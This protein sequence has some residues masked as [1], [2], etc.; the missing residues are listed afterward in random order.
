M[1]V[2]DFFDQVPSDRLSVDAVLA[3]PLL[4]EFIMEGDF[5]LNIARVSALLTAWKLAVE[6]GLPSDLNDYF[7]DA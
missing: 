3:N 7:E 6:F 5:T 4:V 2:T 1:K